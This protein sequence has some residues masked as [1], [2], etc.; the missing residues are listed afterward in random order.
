MYVCVFIELT[1]ISNIAQELLTPLRSFEVMQNM[2][3]EDLS[4]LWM[5]GTYIHTV[6]IFL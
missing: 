4:L 1:Y 6:H 5:S 3:D 2:I